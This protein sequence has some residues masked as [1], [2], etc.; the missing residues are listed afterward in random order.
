MVE[1]IITILAVFYAS[2]ALVETDGPYGVL[3]KFRNLKHVDRLGLSSC[4]VCVAFWVAL[5]ASLIL[6]RDHWLLYALGISG[7]VVA[8]ERVTNS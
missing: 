7:A 8:L 1:I 6:Y 4:I 5:I 2:V 3:Y